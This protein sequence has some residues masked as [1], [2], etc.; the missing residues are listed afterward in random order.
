MISGAS[1]SP[2]CK[3]SNCPRT[4][5]STRKVIASWEPRLR[6][7]SNAT[8]LL[9][10]KTDLRDVAG[11]KLAAAM[12]LTELG[13]RSVVVLSSVMLV[14]AAAAQD[15]HYPPDGQQIPPSKCL[16]LRD[17]S[18]ASNLPCSQLDHQVWLAD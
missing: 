11:K 16:V 3:R 15:M 17:D 14:L 5:T 13:I 12:K 2:R 8:F 6:A 4:F 18:E 9:Q 1:S 10:S 7:A